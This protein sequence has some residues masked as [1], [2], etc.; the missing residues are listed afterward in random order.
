VMGDAA[1]P[2]LA[3]N[4]LPARLVDRYGSVHRLSGWPERNS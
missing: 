4:N 1:L 3:A 2:W